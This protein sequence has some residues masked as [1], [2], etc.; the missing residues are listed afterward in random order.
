MEKQLTTRKTKKKVDEILEEEEEEDITCL[1]NKKKGRKRK[2]GKLLKSSFFS[3]KNDENVIDTLDEVSTNSAAQ[4][5]KEKM[6]NI[7]LHLKF[8]NEEFIAFENSMQKNNTL[9]AYTPNISENN[10]HSYTDVR[11]KL[12][13]SEYKETGVPSPITST[14]NAGVLNSEAVVEKEKI[15]ENQD[16]LLCGSSTS[17]CSE[18]ENKKKN[19][20]REVE[21]KIK[22]LNIQLNKNQIFEE[23]NCFWCSYEFHNDPCII[24]KYELKGTIHCYGIFC[25]PECAVAFLMNENDIDDSI[26][27]ERYHLLNSLYA[28]AFH[29]ER[30]IKPAPSPFYFLDKFQGT[31]TI[32]EYRGLLHSHHLYLTIDKP[33]TRILPEI[34][35]DLDEFTMNIFKK[36]NIIDNNDVFMA[37]NNFDNILKQENEGV[38]GF[39]VKRQSLKTQEFKKNKILRERFCVS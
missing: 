21:K 22:R 12:I 13:Q 30:A 27:M 6:K 35:E 3:A 26:K 18:C 19:S 9:L 33:L 1:L 39:S 5:T 4:L 29:Y 34:H 25:S 10:Y 20:M 31:L 16:S 11:T 17:Y 14:A 32:E 24:P 38:S 15:S 36:K 28:K 37:P 8:N 2:G 23:A 7:I